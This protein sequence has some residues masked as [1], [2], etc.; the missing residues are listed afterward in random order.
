LESIV[1]V[2]IGKNRTLSVRI[3]VHLKHFRTVCPY[4]SIVQHRHQALLHSTIPVPDIDDAQIAGFY[5]G[6]DSGR[7]IQKIFII[8]FGPVS[9]SA[10]KSSQQTDQL[11]SRFQ[12]IFH[13]H[14]QLGNNND[15]FCV[16]L[17][18]KYRKFKN[19]VF[20]KKLQ[21]F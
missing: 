8:I 19:I 9:D 14:K 7:C 2:F 18:T 4:V 17:S 15:G 16:K 5:N 1:Q 13:P 21:Q 10:Q 6:L 11:H 12:N 20:V 3:K